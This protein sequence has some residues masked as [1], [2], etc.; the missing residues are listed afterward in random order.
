MALHTEVGLT[1][2]GSL[3]LPRPVDTKT[4]KGV[5]LLCT[6]ALAK[7]G[8][9]NFTEQI[10]VPLNHDAY[11]GGD[12]SPVSVMVGIPVRLW[13]FPD[14]ENYRSREGGST[15]RSA[16]ILMTQ[17]SSDPYNFGFIMTKWQA[18]HGNVLVVRDD[19]QDL[20][21]GDVRAL[22]NYAREHIFAETKN[23]VKLLDKSDEEKA[24]DL[25]LSI[26]SKINK[27]HFQ[28]CSKQ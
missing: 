8:Y 14:T 1:E 16:K 4:I 20:D 18:D 27:N 5:K 23:V 6:S 17:P 15:N 11:T 9:A 12:R 7:V 21:E 3:D 10:A 26:M 28:A 2:Y 25:C 19:R 13:K 22:V 24:K